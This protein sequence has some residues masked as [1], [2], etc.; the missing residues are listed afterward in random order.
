MSIRQTLLVLQNRDRK[1]SGFRPYVEG[2]PGTPKYNF[3]MIRYDTPGQPIAL[4]VSESASIIGSI[5]HTWNVACLG[6]LSEFLV[7]YVNIV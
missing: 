1:R 6:L 4:I 3:A 5:S 2:C 7:Y